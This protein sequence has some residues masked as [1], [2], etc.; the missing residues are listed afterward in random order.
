MEL[1]FCVY[2]RVRNVTVLYFLF[3]EVM[4]CLR[5]QVWAYVNEILIEGLGNK[6]RVGNVTIINRYFCNTVD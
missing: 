6:F 3:R 1:K 2:L 5:Y 4:I